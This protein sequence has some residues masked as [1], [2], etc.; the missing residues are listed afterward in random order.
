MAMTLLLLWATLMCQEPEPLK[1]EALRHVD[2]LRPRIEETCD[3]LWEWAE[4]ALQEHKSAAHLK[5]VLKAAGFRIESGVAGLPTAFVASWGTGS[6]VLG[7]L[8]E[9]DALPGVSQAATTE[10]RAL[11][12]DGAGHGCGHNVFGAG[13]LGAALALRQVMADHG[14]SGTIRLFGCPAEETGVGKLFM[15]RAGV[16][17]GLDACLHWHPGL[18][19]LTD[20]KT[21]LSVN[22]FTVEFYGQAAHAAL[23]PWN[24]RSALDAVEVMTTAVN[25]YREHIRPEARIHYV[26]ADG[27]RVPNVVPDYAKVWFYVRDPAKNRVD[28]MY[29]RLQEM[30]EG[31]A[32]ATATTHKVVLKSG[33][34]GILHNQPLID[35]I[36]A[37]LV[38][39]GA[40]SWDEK[41]TA[42]ARGVQESVGVPVEGL[43]EVIEPLQPIGSLVLSG[44]TD[45]GE[46]SLITPLAGFWV[47]S[48]GRGLP[49]HSWASTACHGTTIG[50]KSALVAAKVMAC[51]GVDILVDQDLRERSRAAFRRGTGGLPYIS[52]L[53]ADTPAPTVGQH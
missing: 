13:S 31:A 27:G 22:S 34:N 38:R 29:K 3:L 24:G 12:K 32:L 30:A 33:L 19:T 53:P 9:Y 40:P 14:L 20:T 5:G 26:I 21:W 44:S 6:P 10:R 49:W 50:H 11:V 47:T 45:V 37:N 43:S 8:A 7:I 23:D 52:P 4:P 18:Q 46:V 35:A 39:V 25:L 17:D 48:A 51:T 2:T 28:V 15:A 16:F 36:Q 1:Q 41:E 42:F